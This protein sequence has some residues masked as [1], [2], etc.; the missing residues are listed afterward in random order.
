M[1]AIIKDPSPGAASSVSFIDPKP[2]EE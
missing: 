1:S 2:K